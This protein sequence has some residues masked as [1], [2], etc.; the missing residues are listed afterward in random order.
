MSF[1]LIDEILQ[2]RLFVIDHFW[3][4]KAIYPVHV[5][6]VLK[7]WR[8]R[9]FINDSDILLARKTSKLALLRKMESGIGHFQL[10]F[11]KIYLKTYQYIAKNKILLHI[12][13]IILVHICCKPFKIAW[14]QNKFCQFSKMCST[15]CLSLLF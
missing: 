2:H 15:V 3:S 4:S 14:I 5:Y 13:I 8:F 11:N 7:I 9:G 6:I 10:S 12:L 1:I